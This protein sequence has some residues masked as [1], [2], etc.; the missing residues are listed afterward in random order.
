[1]WYHVRLLVC[2][3]GT[4][5]ADGSRRLFGIFVPKHITDPVRAAAWTYG[6]TTNQYLSLER[7]A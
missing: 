4:P 5:E 1:V 2:A 6:L 7:R 3:N